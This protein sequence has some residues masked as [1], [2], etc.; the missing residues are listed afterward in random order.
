M[1]KPAAILLLGVFL[2]NLVGYRW[3]I[4]YLENRATA[5]L[6]GTISNSAYSEADLI[7]IK[8]PVTVPYYNNSSVFESAEGEVNINGTYYRFVK[9][10][11]YNDS[12][13]LLCIPDHSRKDL[14]S[15]RDDYFKLVND[16]Q[17]NTSGKKRSHSGKSLEIKK[18]LSDYDKGIYWQ[19]TTLLPIHNTPPYSYV[20]TDCGNLYKRLIEQPPPVKA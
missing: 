1:K 2:F 3:V 18:I 17:Q 8:T 7:S 10:R 11:I 14:I 20:N 13:E 5:S 16:L 6:D 12:V 15:T 4:T 19:L 9:H